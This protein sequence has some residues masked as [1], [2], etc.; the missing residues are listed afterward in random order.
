MATMVYKKSQKLL[1]DVSS[2]LD[3]TV[4]GQSLRKSNM[5]LPN[6]SNSTYTLWIRILTTLSLM[7]YFV[8]HFPNAAILFQSTFTEISVSVRATNRSVL[9]PTILKAFTFRSIVYRQ[10][11]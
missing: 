2:S 1:M 4:I 9:V 8:R 6:G 5:R 3:D 7:L 10:H 11:A